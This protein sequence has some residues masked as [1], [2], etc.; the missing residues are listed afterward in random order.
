MLAQEADIKYLRWGRPFKEFIL[1]DFIDSLQS[2][3]KDQISTD[4]KQVFDLAHLLKAKKKCIVIEDIH[5]LAHADQDPVQFYRRLLSS[6]NLYYVQHNICFILSCVKIPAVFIRENPLLN[7]WKFIDS[8][9]LDSYNKFIK[10]R[11]FSYLVDFLRFNYPDLERHHFLKIGDFIGNNYKRKD[12]HT[13]DF[14]RFVLALLETSGHFDSEI[15][16]EL[17]VEPEIALYETGKIN[18]HLKLLIIGQDEAIQR[19]S[20]AAEIAYLSRRNDHCPKAVFLFVGPSGV[21]KTR[22]CQEMA[23]VLSG[24]K[25]LQI[26]LAEH[27]DRAAVNKLIGLGR[28]YEDSKYGGILTEPVRL[29]PR[30]VLLF[31]ELDHAHYSVTQL[32]YKIFEGEIMDGRGR[33]VSFRECFI[34]MTTNRGCISE[35]LPYEEQRRAIEDK[36]IKEEKKDEKGGSIFSQPFLGRIHSIIQFNELRPPAL[37]RIAQN[38]FRDKI[39]IP[40]EKQ[41]GLKFTF[42]LKE[43]R[44]A[45]IKDNIL[46]KEYAFFEQWALLASNDHV[47]G[48]RRLFQIMDEHLLFPLELFLIRQ[49]G[50]LTSRFEI[51]TFFDPYCPEGQDYDRASILLID[52][53]P[54][55]SD[56][57]SKIIRTSLITIEQ[58]DFE[59]EAG[60]LTPSVILLDLLKG[61]EIVGQKLLANLQE[62]YPDVP[63]CIYSALSEGPHLDKLKSSLWKYGIFDYISKA[64]PPDLAIGIIFRALQERY[65]NVKSKAHKK[66]IK[67]NLEFPVNISGDGIEFVVNREVV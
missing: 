15:Y 26:N 17:P 57:L 14:K 49:R 38:Y 63:V 16:H 36:L 47:Q 39:V 21:G 65:L 8:R 56:T 52:D 13:D 6:C 30:Y 62:R 4:D 20:D 42:H 1:E 40:Y 46:D 28:G 12:L 19:I 53:D 5:F 59:Q 51:K 11:R 25:F 23:R 67:I 2:L 45:L 60:A 55:A 64:D 35:R 33:K 10:N 29:H 43:I 27:N 34:I 22:I 37:V 18:N 50:L 31:D 24:Y 61:G 66:L 9:D 32:F 41:Y 3:N 58:V 54:K 44:P 48:A 7:K